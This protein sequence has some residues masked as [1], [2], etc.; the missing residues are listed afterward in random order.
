MISGRTLK[1]LRDSG[2]GRCRYGRGTPPVR[3]QIAPSR[4]GD[5]GVRCGRSVLSTRLPVIQGAVLLIA[6]LFLLINLIVDLLYALVDPRI[7][8]S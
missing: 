2:F 4:R 8:L 1:C 6:A 3:L 5:A 7:R